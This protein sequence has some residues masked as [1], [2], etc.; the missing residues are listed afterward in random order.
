MI[1]ET[2]PIPTPKAIRNV[3]L[4]YYNKFVPAQYAPFA[5]I[6]WNVAKTIYLS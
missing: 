3:T 6:I 4:D 5:L 2:L 1:Q